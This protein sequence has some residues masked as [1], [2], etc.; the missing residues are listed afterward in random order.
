MYMCVIS[1]DLKKILLYI[2][3]TRGLEVKSLNFIH[4]VFLSVCVYFQKTFQ[5]DDQK[6]ASLRTYTIIVVLY[7]SICMCHLSL[8]LDS[9]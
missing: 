7:S 6:A 1:R 8:S 4:G 5:K 2:Y 3:N 9:F